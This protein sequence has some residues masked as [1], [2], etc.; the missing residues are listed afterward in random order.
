MMQGNI[1]AVESCP[2]ID[3]TAGR[4]KSEIAQL[5]GTVEV[6]KDPGVDPKSIT[7]FNFEKDKSTVTGF[8][9]T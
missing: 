2:W 9:K 7:I 3:M 6:R 4:C 5:Q 8:E 1:V